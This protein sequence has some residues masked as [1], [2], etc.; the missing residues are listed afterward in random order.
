[1]RALALQAA[2][3]ALQLETITAGLR[4]S[5]LRLIRGVRRNASA[6][7]AALSHIGHDPL[8]SRFALRLMHAR[9]AAGA[10]GSAIRHARVH[11]LQLR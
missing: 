2:A 4:A 6:L 9:S 8:S 3:H 1:M 5:F 10:H 11:E 7:H